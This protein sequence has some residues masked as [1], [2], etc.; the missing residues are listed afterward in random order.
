[1]IGKEHLEALQK[2]FVCEHC[3]VCCRIG[4]NMKLSGHDADMIKDWLKTEAGQGVVLDMLR[5]TEEP[6]YYMF[7]RS[8]P[9]PLF[10]SKSNVCK[11]HAY[12][13]GV[14][15]RY[16]FLSMLDGDY[17]LQDLFTCRGAVKALST[18]FGVQLF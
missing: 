7:W 5:I 3:G 2:I 10:D 9:C 13:P 12:K 14:C 16:P 1:M 6:E 18:Y 8:S 11:A 17:V 15:Q 4:G